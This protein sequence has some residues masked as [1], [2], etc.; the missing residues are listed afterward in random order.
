MGNVFHSVSLPPDGPEKD[1]IRLAS[2]LLRGKSPAEL[3]A[4]THWDDGAWAKHYLPGVRGIKIP[5]SDIV[6]EYQDRLK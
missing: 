6:N 3:V 1:S 4:I 2:D 5:N